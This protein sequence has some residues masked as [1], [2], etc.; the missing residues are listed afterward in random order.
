MVDGPLRSALEHW[1]LKNHSPHRHR[2]RRHDHHRR[3]RGRTRVCLLPTTPLVQLCPPGPIPTQPAHNVKLHFASVN[4]NSF[5]TAP[6]ARPLGS[7]FGPARYPSRHPG[8]TRSRRQTGRQALAG[9]QSV[10]L[11]VCQ[12]VRQAGGVKV[13]RPNSAWAMSCVS[14]VRNCHGTKGSVTMGNG[15]GPCGPAPPF[16][17][18]G[19]TKTSTALK[20]P[21]SSR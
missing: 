2:H 15:F 6:P 13:A 1:G 3:T 9:S 19:Q 20:R 18:T 17:P 10:S 14:T 5:V 11:S 7:W 8:A 16:G 4:P 21:E 12:S